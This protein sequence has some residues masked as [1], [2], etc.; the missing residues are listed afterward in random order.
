LRPDLSR[1]YDRAF[2]AEYGATN[3]PY[4]ETARYLADLLH[5]LFAPRRLIDL[6]C[7]CGVYADAFRRLGTE[8]VAV[9]GVAAPPEFSFPGPVE[10]RDLT[11]PLDDDW[12][13]FDLALCLEVGEHI[14]EEFCG[15]FLAN[16]TRFSDTLVL[17]CAPPYQGGVHH[18]N[19]RPK[20]WWKARLAEIGWVYDRDRTGVISETCKADRPPLLWMCQQVSVYVRAALNPPPAGSA[21][22]APGTPP[23]GSSGTRAAR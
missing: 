13:W 7:G 10:I 20:R 16:I 5:R 12:G 2:F 19:E 22:G 23:S 18:V 8:V 6:G 1:I 14:P 11:V 21:A 4:V 17:S 15:T 9:D 3:R